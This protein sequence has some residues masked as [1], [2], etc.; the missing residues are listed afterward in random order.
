MN[1]IEEHV[2]NGLILC[3]C[4]K[5]KNLGYRLMGVPYGCLTCKRNV[6]I[7]DLPAV[8]VED[9][10]LHYVRW[11]D[12]EEVEPL[13]QKDIKANLLMAREK[14]LKMKEVADKLSA[15]SEEQRK[16]LRDMGNVKSR[17]HSR[18]V[19]TQKDKIFNETYMTVIGVVLSRVDD[20]ELGNEG[21]ILNKTKP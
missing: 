16:K 4:P 13:S 7:K 3:K 14:L 2:D 5:C 20:L 10:L 12:N 15:M 19:A 11:M 8:L 18:W 1:L 17:Q 6:E 21:S 9:V